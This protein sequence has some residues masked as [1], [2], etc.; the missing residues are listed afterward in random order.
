M[1]HWRCF[2][3]L[4]QRFRTG[5]VKGPH[6]PVRHADDAVFDV[7]GLVSDFPDRL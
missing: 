3:S 1:L 5:N 6:Q 2:E 4:F 7:D